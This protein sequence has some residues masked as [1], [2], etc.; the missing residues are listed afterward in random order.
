MNFHN[1]VKVI[2]ESGVINIEEICE[3]LLIKMFDIWNNAATKLEQIQQSQTQL[4][5][6][7][8][9]SG[10]IKGIS[11]I[12]ILDSKTPFYSVSDS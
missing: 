5:Q 6:P 8:T 4:Q 7:H 9:S 3:I 12:S 1:W 10:S 11:L 2:C